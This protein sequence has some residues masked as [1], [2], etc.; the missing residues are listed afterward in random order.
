MSLETL[1][2][3]RI[4]V[5]W[6][7]SIAGVLVVASGSAIYWLDKNINKIKEEIVQ[8]K[9]SEKDAEIQQANKKAKEAD[10]RAEEAAKKADEANQKAEELDKKAKMSARN[11]T[12]TYD[13]NG[14]K[15]Q[16]SGG[17]INV[18]AGEEVMVFQQI[19]EFAKAN[20][21]PNLIKLC[22]KQ[23]EKTPDWYTPFLYLG[24]AQAD[25]GLKDEA[26]ENLKYVVD[27]TPGDP[28]YAKASEV[29]EI[30]EQSE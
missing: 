13:F 3:I 2:I 23:I 1:Q 20:D 19:I 10:K 28:E 14:A 27:N 22:E 16:T 6:V 30:L 4:V 12:S 18:V 25:M 17:K 26:I 21:L 24:M 9:F 29:L 11:V 8:Q 7:G 5:I 15:R